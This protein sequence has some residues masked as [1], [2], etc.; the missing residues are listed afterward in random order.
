[1]FTQADQIASASRFVTCSQATLGKAI[2]SINDVEDF[3]GDHGHVLF[4][5]PH[6][7]EH[8]PARAKSFGA[9][10]Q[11][12]RGWF[13][14]SGPGRAFGSVVAEDGSTCTVVLK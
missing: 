9:K 2:G 3:G 6:Q 11:Q 4:V 10:F 5:D 13:S 7:W 14:Q 8:L 1:M 12:H